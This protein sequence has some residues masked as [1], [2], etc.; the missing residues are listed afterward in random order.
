M[1]GGLHQ[2]GPVQE[3][4][5][6]HPLGEH[7][8]V[9][10]LDGRMHLLEHVGRI[11]VA[12]HLHDAFHPIGDGVLVI[13][14]S[15]DALP[16]QVAVF[17]GTQVGQV[18]GFA[19]HG[20]H[21]DASQVFQV[22]DQTHAAHDVALLAAGQHA[23]AAVGVVVH[24]GLLNLAQRQVVLEQTLGVD[25]EQELRSQAAEIAHGCHAWNLLQARD[26]HPLVQV[27]EFAQGMVFTLEDIAVD[28]PRRGGQRIQ[29]G[30][31]VVREVHVSDA[32]AH[33][34]A[35]PVILRAV[36][37]DQHDDRQAEGVAAAH[38]IQRRDA[39][40][41]PLQR[42]RN[43]L[44]DLFGGQARDLGHHLDRGVGDVRIRIDG[45]PGP[46]VHAECRHEHEGH[47]DQP[48]ATQG[49]FYQ[50]LHYSLR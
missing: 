49:Q 1:E 41:R 11:L 25:L 39:V 37:E 34:L 5:D 16:L 36:V 18:H 46:A 45:E 38:H 26:D 20:L 24:D 8:P 17:E 19:V 4:P 15:H 44:L 9:Q 40:E 2:F 12:E 43:L 50:P 42:D 30:D 7:V 10:F 29:L 31:G 22:L 21:D 27:R 6:P 32:F 23:A 28:L 48:P 14:E 3:R 13:E 47:C 35:G 33:A